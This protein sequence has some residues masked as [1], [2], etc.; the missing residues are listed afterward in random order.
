MDRSIADYVKAGFTLVIL[1][2]FIWLFGDAILKTFQA[3]DAVPRFSEGHSVVA[4][5]SAGLIAGVVATQLGQKGTKNGISRLGRAAFPIF[6]QDLTNILGWVIVAVYALL[7]VLGIVAW[8]MKSGTGTAGDP[9]LVPDLVRNLASFVLA[10]IIG[11][12]ARVYDINEP[13]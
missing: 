7:G 4:A 12:V 3:T 5:A 8:I 9:N 2:L 6:S 13:T 1:G 10:L 11:V